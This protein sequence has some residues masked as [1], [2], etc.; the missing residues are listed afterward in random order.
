MQV[1]A[2]SCITTDKVTRIKKPPVIH[3]AH[4]HSTRLQQ[5]ASTTTM[6]DFFKPTVLLHMPPHIVEAMDTVIID[7]DNRCFCQHQL[8]ESGSMSL[9]SSSWGDVK[10][11][12]LATEVVEI[13]NHALQLGLQEIKW[14]RDD[15]EMMGCVLPFMLDTIFL[16]ASGVLHPL[17]MISTVLHELAHIYV[18]KCGHHHKKGSQSHCQAWVEA[19]QFLTVLFGVRY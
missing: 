14:L 19:T 13:M 12:T 6:C 7:D 9:T 2:G 5:P 17:D 16:R 8:D 10:A 4:S 15:S 1:T 3:S 18:E 11:M